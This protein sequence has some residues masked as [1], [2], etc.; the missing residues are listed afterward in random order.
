V[1]SIL[2][3]IGDT[4][5][6]RVEKDIYAKLEEFNPSGSVKDR[7]VSYMIREAIERGKLTKDKIILDA[8]SGNTGISIA[9]IATSLGYKSLLVIPESMSVEKRK[10]TRALGAEIILVSGGMDDA[11]E[12]AK[13]LARDKKYFYLDQFSNGFNVQ[14]HYETTGREIWEQTDSKV[15]HIVAGIGSG[16]TI[17]G[18]GKFLKEKN[19]EIIVIGVEPRGNIQGLKDLSKNKKP[20]IL[21]FSVIDEIVKVTDK[22]A[23]QEVRKLVKLGIFVGQSS[24]AAFYAGKKIKK[25]VIVVIFADGGER[26]LS[27]DLFG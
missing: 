18:I 3:F 16:G 21:D 25:G 11:V 9:M 8:T 22:Q 2:D 23:N 19:P 5:L 27:T 7:P 6:M 20:K 12:K 24:G 14:S 17:T 13:H 1:D 10:I 4:P 15:T 26:Y